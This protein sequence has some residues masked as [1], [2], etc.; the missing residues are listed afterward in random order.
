MKLKS[1]KKIHH[2]SLRYDIQTATR[3]FFASNILIHNS[4]LIVSKYKGNIILRTRGTTD[5]TKLNNG[6]ELEVFKATILPKVIA[7]A[8]TKETWNSSFLFE[9]VSPN[10]RIILNYGDNPTWYL[11]GA[12]LHSEYEL[13]FQ[14]VL[15]KL[16]KL[17]GCPRPPVYTFPSVEDLMKDV[18]GWK[19]K[20]GIVVYSN[21]GQTLHKVKGAWYLALHR[22]K[23]ALASFDKVIDVW[24]EQNMPSYQTFEQFIT[25][26][27]DWELWTQIRGDASRICEGYKEV[28]RMIEAMREFISPLKGIPRKNAAEKII[29]SYGKTNRA[30]FCFKLLDGKELGKDDQKKLLYQVLKK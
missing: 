5:A 23:E 9:W 13:V 15:D 25:S 4:L 3:N 30:S 7:F 26:Q 16:A 14:S 21:E 8:G 19:G 28:L 24:F 2:E 18:E 11:V 29:G 12:V 10:Q 22:M 20:E 6:Y 17:F 1:I 27:F